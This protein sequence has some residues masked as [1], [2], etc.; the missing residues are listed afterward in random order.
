MADQR[1]RELE[2]RW[3]ESG[4]LD[5]RLAWLT[6]RG[7]AG[8]L[9]PGVA[10]LVAGLGGG[11]LPLQRVALLAYLRAPAAVE[12]LGDEV[13]ALASYLGELGAVRVVLGDPTDA[14]EERGWA[15]GLA[16]WG[17]RDAALAMAC[18]TRPVAVAMATDDGGHQGDPE[19]DQFERPWRAEVRQRVGVWCLNLVDRVTAAAPLEGLTPHAE[20]SEAR[21]EALAACGAA[22]LCVARQPQRLDLL[23][24]ACQS[25]LTTCV[26]AA[27]RPLQELLAAGAPELLARLGA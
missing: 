20:A 10:G 9:A 13:V 6:A 3:R 7:R 2:R 24:G 22:L 27:Q 21:A 17:A 5:D 26:A 23:Q 16:H 4:A 14:E 12:V 18:L 19:Y 1:L 25:W 8:E 11:S 15:A